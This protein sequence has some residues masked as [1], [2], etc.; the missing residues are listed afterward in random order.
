MIDHETFLAR[1]ALQMKESAIRKMG[2]VG[3]RIPDLIS[4]AAGFPCPDL[5]LWE[6]LRD[7]A[8]SILDSRDVR[9]LQYGPT[10]GYAP[11]LEVV[12]ELLDERGIRSTTE[13]LQITSGSQQALDLVARVLCDP[14][15]V[16]LVELPT[17]S[18]AISAMR[19]VRIELVGVKQEPDGIELE[20]LNRTLTEQRS[21]G[22]R[23]A[24]VYVTP[25]F[26]NPSGLMLSR[27]KRRALLEWA[28][29]ESVLIIEDDPYGSLYFDEAAGAGD[30]R[31][32]K[33]DDEHGMVV[34][35][36]SFSKTLAPGL[37]VA[38]ITAAP[39]I[40]SRIEIVK[41]ASDLCTG[42]LDQY[43]V[44][45][46]VR[47]GLIA[48]EAPF[49]RKHYR[50]KRDLMAGALRQECGST[51]KW[52]D[53]QGG[54]FLWVTLPPSIDADALLTRALAERV[55]YVAGSAF[56]VQDPVPNVLRLCFSAPSTERIE[57]GVK[58]FARALKGEITAGGSKES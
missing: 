49:L 16:V 25:N 56:Y 14:G 21:R 22:K 24:A 3:A 11:L 23:V 36:S 54:F 28:A 44:Y 8:I 12:L 46:A 1:G 52:P 47:R 58:R 6:D 43:L 15:D 45:E 42:A 10:R 13:Q 35:L 33:A 18:G 5:F 30:T 41:Q 9:A 51:L 29:R 40:A 4:F 32:I 19:N 27:A 2:S 37:R 39:S 34:Y 7:I 26:Q 48:R 17:Y 57:E 50:H 38:W 31:P 20:S 55:S 53:P